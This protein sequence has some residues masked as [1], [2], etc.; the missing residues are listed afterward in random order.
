MLTLL[1]LGC[2]DHASHNLDIIKGL[3]YLAEPFHCLEFFLIFSTDTDASRFSIVCL[4]PSCLVKLLNEL[5][6]FDYVVQLAAQVSVIAV[7]PFLDIW[8]FRV[9]HV[10][11]P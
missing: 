5:V 10:E 8:A 9:E 2:R 7:R 1:F 6:S 3:W 4:M 11:F